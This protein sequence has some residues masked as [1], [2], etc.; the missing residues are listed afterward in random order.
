MKAR[1][2]TVD[3]IR[4]LA[5]NFKI[6]TRKQLSEY[7]GCP[8]TV[9]ARKM[10]ELGLHKRKQTP[11][12]GDTINRLTIRGFSSKSVGSQ[13]KTFAICDCSCGNKTEQLLTTIMKHTIKSC[14]CL[15]A[16]LASERTKKRNYK[17]GK[18]SLRNR[19]YRIWC[20]MKSRCYIESA[21]GYEYWG[22]RGIEVC[23]EWRDSFVAF[24]TWSLANGYQEDLSIDRIDV[25]GDYEP[26]NCRWADQATQSN[27]RR[28]T[29]YVTAWGEKKK[30][31]EWLVDA[32][33]QAG[34]T[35]N[36]CYRIKNGW[37][38]EDAISLP[39]NGR[40]PYQS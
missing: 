35:G 14:G 39:L 21:E 5:D 32:R 1:V 27:N 13:N 18:G 20:S 38:P 31:K 30:L 17:H 37:R 26:S 10:A 3:E 16:E 8:L 2:W 36:I 12:I 25:D 29:V 7:I 6:L 22:G 40:P 11:K 9:L 15:K 28:D 24:E 19:M 23:P 33:C 4:Y 34:S